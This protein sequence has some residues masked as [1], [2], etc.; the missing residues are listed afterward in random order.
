MKSGAIEERIID[1]DFLGRRRDLGEHEVIQGEVGGNSAGSEA[2]GGGA[3][4]GEH[5][6]LA[7]VIYILQ[8]VAG[9]R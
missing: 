8:K 4:E 7:E 9:M 2:E 1:L 6:G 3:V 5:L